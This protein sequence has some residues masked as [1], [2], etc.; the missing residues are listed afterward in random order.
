MQFRE[1]P[2]KDAPAGKR[3]IFGGLIFPRAQS[4][5]TRN[6]WEESVEP[7]CTPRGQMYNAEP[8]EYKY[9]FFD[10][11]FLLTDLIKTG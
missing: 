3:D 7:F 4:Y 2:F 9:S 8:L 1:G 6:G 10:V 11:L 5:R